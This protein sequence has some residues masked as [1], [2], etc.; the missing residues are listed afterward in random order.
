[1]IF[2][3]D[4]PGVPGPQFNA[5]S[6]LDLELERETIERIFH[7]NTLRVYSRVRAGMIAPVDFD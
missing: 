5:L 2:G 6:F 4:W 7:K 3:T 1:M